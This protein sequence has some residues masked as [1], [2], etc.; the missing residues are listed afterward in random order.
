MVENV[1]S[2]SIAA[3]LHK[4][5]VSTMASMIVAVFRVMYVLHGRTT[6]GRSYVCFYA[7]VF[8]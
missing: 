8:V 3:L 2:L 1:M 7:K 6:S 5:Q 4:K